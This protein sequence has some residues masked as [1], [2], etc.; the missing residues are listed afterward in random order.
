MGKVDFDNYAEDYENVLSDELKKFDSESG[1]FAEY[2]IKIVKDTTSKIPLRILDFGCGIGRNTEFLKE[3]FSKAEIT[4]CDISK[5]SI[6]FAKRKNP[7]C[8]FFILDRENI[9]YN[10]QNFD[11]IFTSC[12]FHHIEPELRKETIDNIYNMLKPNGEFY[13]FEHNPFNPITRKIVKDC[14]WDT[15]AILLKPVETKKLLLNAGFKN[16][17]KKYTLFFPKFLSF[18]RPVER[19]MGFLPLG[20]QYYF[21]GKK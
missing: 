16:L 14:V 4:G 10:N 12:V 19:G 20:G 13:I 17:E 6:Q 11:I 15:D 5:K 9:E 7:K 8:S 18:M 1:Y 2:K 3:Y 21:K